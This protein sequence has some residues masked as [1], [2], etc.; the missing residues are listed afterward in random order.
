MR[1]FQ[2]FQSFK[3]SRI[4]TRAPDVTHVVFENLETLNLETLAFYYLHQMRHL[5]HHAA[6]GRRIRTLDNLVE[7]RK[8]QPFDDQFMFYRGANRRA[9]PLDVH[10]PRSCLRYRFRCHPNP[11][12][13]A[14]VAPAS[15]RLSGGRPA[16]QPRTIALPR[17]SRAEPPRLPCSSTSS[18]RRTL[19]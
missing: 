15:R 13:A 19:P 5:F 16:R 3:V 9:H 10:L 7:P 12:H 1:R 11:L 18:M 6:N 14:C 17:S 4:K 8:T 2:D